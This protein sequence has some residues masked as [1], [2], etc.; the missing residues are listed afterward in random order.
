ME[1]LYFWNEQY[2]LQAF[3]SFN[4]EFE[5]VFAGG[6]LALDRSRELKEVFTSFEPGQTR[7]GSFW[8]RRRVT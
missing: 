8:I 5:I 4:D 2:L 1:H 3:L 7:P 6:I